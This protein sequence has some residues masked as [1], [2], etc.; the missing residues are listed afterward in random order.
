MSN[1]TLSANPSLTLSNVTN[2]Q[3]RKLL[4]LEKDPTYQFNMQAERW[5]EINRKHNLKGIPLLQELDPVRF[6]FLA[7]EGVKV[8]IPSNYKEADKLTE[9]VNKVT[10]SPIQAKMVE[11]AM[12][13][14]RANAECL[15]INFLIFNHDISG[16]MQGFEQIIA[17]ANQQGAAA[18]KGSKDFNN[19][20]IHTAVACTTFN[21]EQQIR[22]SFGHLK[23][24]T[25]LEASDIVPCF[26]TDL[27]GAMS[28][29][30]TLALAIVAEARRFPGLEVQVGI[31][32][33][34]DGCHYYNDSQF[35][36]EETI[37]IVKEVDE[38]ENIYLGAMAM[39]EEALDYF[40]ELGFRYDSQNEE[41]GN[42]MFVKKNQ[43][44][45]KLRQRVR[46]AVQLL[47]EKSQKSKE[48]LS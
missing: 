16:S 32:N 35:T 33:T 46:R 45:A 15:K 6:G 22:S 10:A 3:L 11:D 24:Y 37:R 1:T 30:C 34:S 21:H 14:I 12:A 13:F 5:H 20:D 44:H 23:D 7:E 48:S 18:V 39:T 41:N 4:K 29:M 26:L 28:F 27:D 8:Y 31:V 38:H 40:Q 42:L 47:S 9:T 19:P 17:I 25:P 36:R 43:D 2:D